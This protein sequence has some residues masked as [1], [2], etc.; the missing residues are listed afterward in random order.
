MIAAQGASF[1]GLV[2]SEY[3]RLLLADGGIIAG[4][5]RP[6]GRAV[7]TDSPE[8]GYI[9]SGSWPFASGSSHATWFAAECMVY[10]GDTPRLDASG[11]DVSRMTF[12]PREAVTIVDTWDTL[13]LRGTASHDFTVDGAF[14]PAALGFQMLVDPPQ[15]PW[16]LYRALPL[17]FI[18]HGAQ[19]LGVARGA[20]ETAHDIA[21]SKRGWGNVPLSEVPRISAAIAEATAHYESAAE[22]LYGASQ[23]LWDLVQAG[24]DDAGLRA[25]VRLA[26]SHAASASVQAVDIV[27]RALATSSIFTK[28]F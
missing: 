6:T 14:V 11:E 5:A 9:V 22:Y 23:R 1:A 20:L 18:G 27:H 16:A 10:D 13:G 25:R 19:S 12:V 4:T 8:P 28:S 26:N 17:I 3:G 15:H 2:P 21:N 7:W 24:G